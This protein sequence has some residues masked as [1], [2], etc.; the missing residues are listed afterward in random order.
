MIHI[1]AGKPRSGKS[2]RIMEV[3]IYRKLMESEAFI[4]TNLSLRYDRLQNYCDEHGGTFHVRD[5]IRRLEDHQL[6]DWYRYHEF[7]TLDVPED[8]VSEIDYSPVMED[9]RYYVGGKRWAEDG[10]P[11]AM[12]GTVYVIDEAQ[13]IF[14]A[15][16]VNKR[17]RHAMFYCQ[18]HGKLG[19]TVFFVCQNT[20]HLYKGLRDLAQDFTYCRNKALEKWG[21]FRG[22]AKFTAKTYLS[23][24][25]NPDTQVACET[26][27][28]TLNKALADCYDTSAG[29]GM[30]G[31]GRADN[32]AR[33]KGVSLK[34]AVLGFV[35]A[36][37][38]V[39]WVVIKLPALMFS[40][41]KAVA[42]AGKRP[43]AAAPEV[44]VL[45][46][47]VVQ[48]EPVVPVVVPVKRPSGLRVR[49][50]VARGK[51]VQVVLSDGTIITEADPDLESVNLRRGVRY[52]G[53][54][55]P[56]ERITDQARVVV[57][58]V[59][60]ETGPQRVQDQEEPKAFVPPLEP[61]RPANP[62]LSTIEVRPSAELGRPSW[63]SR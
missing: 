61:I 7:H 6:V 11:N 46:S 60:R 40:P 43:A 47:P 45:P 29:V 58:D 23:R 10:E 30:P 36:G 9:P 12:R 62:W 32:R 2:L 1:Y 39:W 54:L 38:A 17:F 57:R 15:G 3:A 63:S 50:V 31:G 13:T 20:D 41:V 16:A 44:Q 34:W 24:L 33:A 35:V 4:F 53:E 19:H 49:G 21:V 55:L 37:V 5:R 51:L 52:R 26:K 22:D 25:T 28:Y 14:K 59:E 48:A 27:D 56:F 8:D 18:Q 42:E